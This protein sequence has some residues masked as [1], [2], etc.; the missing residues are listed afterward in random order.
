RALLQAAA[1]IGRRFSRAAVLALATANAAAGEVH[2]RLLTQRGLIRPVAD[3]D[4]RA[5]HHALVRNVVYAGIP[6]AVRADLHER[7]AELLDR[8]D[9]P[10]EVVGYHLE[11][12]YRYRSEFSPAEPYVR[13][14]GRR[15]AERLASAAERAV[16]G[17]DMRSAA[18]LFARAAD[19]LPRHEPRR[20]RL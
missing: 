2:L 6:K 8:R 7:V 11:R 9:T 20:P 14:V 1:V 12:S 19:L 4:L 13:E 5:F 16:A 3:E 18:A 15:A 17:E 10:D